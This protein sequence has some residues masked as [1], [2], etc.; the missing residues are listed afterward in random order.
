MLQFL[1]YSQLGVLERVSLPGG[2][3]QSNLGVAQK[4][5]LNATSK[6]YVTPFELRNS[7]LDW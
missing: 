4:S 2:I 7:P 6:F 5:Y 1:L 3:S